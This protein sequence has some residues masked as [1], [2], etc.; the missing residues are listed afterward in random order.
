M[1]LLNLRI[2]PYIQPF[3]QRLALLEIERL[4]NSALQPLH[5]SVPSTYHTHAVLSRM[6]A[7][8]LAERTAYWEWVSEN[9]ETFVT[10]Q[11]E[12]EATVN[13]ARNGKHLSDIVMLQNKLNLEPPGRRCLR[14]ATH[15][16]HEYRGKFFPQLVRALLNI[17]DI[18]K[19]AI[20]GD[21]M[22]GSGTT[23]VEAVLGGHTAQALD[24][25]PLSVF[26][27]RTKCGILSTRPQ[28]LGNAFAT[29]RAT[30]TRAKTGGAMPYFASLPEQDQVYLSRW[31]SADVLCAL[32]RISSA[33]SELRGPLIRDFFRLCQSNILRKVSWQKEDDLR[34]RREE[35]QKISFQEA[36]MTFIVETERN[37]K[38]V[39]AFLG[40]EQA[41]V[42]KCTIRSGDARS[43]DCLWPNQCDVIITSPPY[44]TALP[45]LDTDRLSLIYLG[46]L[47]KSN[48]RARDRLMIGNREISER[49]R[50][51]LWQQFKAEEVRL[52]DEAKSLIHEIHNQN[53]LDPNAGFRRK[54]LPSLLFQ[55][56]RD[57][58]KAIGA[59]RVSVRK[60]G[61][62]FVVV[63]D[64]QTV[65]NGN[66]IRIPTISLLKEIS[67]AQGFETVEV[68]PMEM[69][70]NRQIH[71]RNATP[72]ES[73][74]WLRNATQ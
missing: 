4:T 41:P 48:L 3:E 53:A 5:G 49:C 21:P 13:I 51:D 35:A 54:N 46:L 72:S 9:G 15:G 73:I 29:L 39:A 38:H 19:K 12:R 42:G 74:I 11:V 30:L 32:D 6:P 70:V 27:T 23:A 25:N 47:P 66:T 67:E 1:R 33:I 17:T 10:R 28:L 61:D 14:Y 69:L 24:M 68:L 7:K 64:N 58:Q 60:G 22:C 26:M 56:F 18:P 31:F 37:A 63:G 40:S 45:Y 16:I 62:V 50:R 59:M 44:A 52:P 20:V 34:V 55:Y 57:M 71:R 65:A 43:E 36:I 2:K 8:Q